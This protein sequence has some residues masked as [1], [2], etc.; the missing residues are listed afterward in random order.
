MEERNAENRDRLRRIRNNH[1]F[2][3][4]VQMSLAKTMF[5]AARNENKRLTQIYRTL[6]RTMTMPTYYNKIAQDIY[7][8]AHHHVA[9]PRHEQ[10]LRIAY[11]F[12][13]SLI[14]MTLAEGENMPRQATVSWLVGCS[15]ELGDNNLFTMIQGWRE[16][17][18]P[19][20]A[21]N[22]VA[23]P[24]L[25]GRVSCKFMPSSSPSNRPIT[26]PND[27][28]TSRLYS[29][30]PTHTRIGGGGNG[31]SHC[32][33]KLMSRQKELMIAARN[34]A[35]ESATQDP[36]HCAFAA[37]TL[38]EKDQYA[39]DTIAQ[40]IEQAGS[41]NKMSPPS[42]FNIAR[43]MEQHH[44]S[45]RACRLALL[46]SA[47]VYIP[48]TADTHHLI[49]DLQWACML[50]LNQGPNELTEL[51][52]ILVKN[53]HCAPV[54]ANLL[55]KCLMASKQ[56]PTGPIAPPMNVRSAAGAAPGVHGGAV[57]VAGGVQSY[58][59]DL[60]NHF[61]VDLSLDDRTRRNN[62]YGSGMYNPKTYSLDRAPL[63]ILLNAAVSAFIDT[64]MTRLEHISP[65]HYS[66]FIDFLS[67]AQETM[68]MA[69]NGK[70]EFASLL[71]KIKTLYKGKKKL[72][73]LVRERFG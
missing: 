35:I 51:V 52:R 72:M 33:D 24:I 2:Y 59:H 37:L 19:T 45:E 65:R 71:E 12:G 3:F 44:M 32:L 55:R 38:C 58:P 27:P 49:N 60:S 66:D 11:F 4:D 50:T 43:Y 22:F 21:V 16:Y 63:S 5:Y 48:I 42:L 40:V 67:R 26:D 53:V 34:L 7:Q 68:I 41:T 61:Y 39:F 31:C 70:R 20:E 73:S 36:A 25:A 8:L 69:P 6:S 29:R 28:G 23:T 54:L 46:A 57:G 62:E 64:V 9:D 17:F 56:M 10:L 15:S 13:L 1:L 30:C 47:G 14:R 18:T